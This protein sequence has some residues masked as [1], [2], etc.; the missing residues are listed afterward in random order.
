[1]PSC[2]SHTISEGRIVGVKNFAF[3]PI[4]CSFFEYKCK[5]VWYVVRYVK[6]VFG[7]NVGPRRVEVFV[8][9]VTEISVDIRENVVDT[10]PQ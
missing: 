4:N 1:M 7:Y 8:N 3:S 2:T 10:I 6:W 9:I 5:I